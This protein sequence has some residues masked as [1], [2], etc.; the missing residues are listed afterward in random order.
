M[1]ITFRCP[2]CGDKIKESAARFQER[3]LFRCSHCGFGIDLNDHEIG[4]V[5]K[6]A[7]QAAKKLRGDYG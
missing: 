3:E 1:R 2:K 4:R 7:I 5:V 6:K